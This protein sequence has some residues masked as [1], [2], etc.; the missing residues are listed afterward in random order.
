MYLQL[1]LNASSFINL[2]ITCP[3]CFPLIWLAFTEWVADQKADQAC[4]MLPR[5][6]DKQCAVKPGSVLSCQS[7]HPSK[8]QFTHS[9][10]SHFNLRKTEFMH[11]HTISPP[12]G[13]KSVYI[14][15]LAENIREQLCII[16]W[17]FAEWR[18]LTLRALFNSHSFFE[19]VLIDSDLN[20]LVCRKTRYCPPS[21]KRTK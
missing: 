16:T 11:I 13:K 17:Q 2:H 21:Q 9:V 15:C 20:I 12:K 5:Y 1:L 8:V 3:I 14:F 4:S 6:W 7:A 19:S 10:R 18:N